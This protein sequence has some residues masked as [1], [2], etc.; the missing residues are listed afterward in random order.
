MELA[1]VND[2]NQLR[3]IAPSEV[4]TP[5][6]RTTSDIHFLA[7][8]TIPIAVEELQKKHTIPVFAKDNESTIS[9]QEFIETVSYVTNQIF[10]GEQILKPAIRVS[11]PI[12][13]RIPSAVGKPA[14]EL[15]EHEKTLYFERMA[16]AIEIASITD[17]VAGNSLN[18]TVGGVRAYN[19]E[20]MHSTKREEHFRLFIGFK[21][22]VCCNLCISTDGFKN[23][24]KVRTIAE[25]AKSAYNLFGEFNV[26]REI[27]K[28][29]SLP[30]TV[31][32][33]SQF[34]QIVGRARLYQ[35]M[36]WKQRKDLP[37]FPLSDSQ[38]NLVVKDYYSDES[39]C[40]N[41]HGDINLWKLFNLFTGANKMSYIDSFLDR[42]VGCQQFVYGLH[43]AIGLNK[44]H[45]FVN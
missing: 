38:V 43:E 21:N 14:K 22:S 30:D 26:Y 8:N 42:N 7:A 29:S 44:H 11:H 32:T 13:G 36:P 35:N 18:L 1:K 23:D 4:V 25:L 45:W 24:I 33:E 28:Y 2:K 17:K 6:Q 5:E 12:K 39:F 40:K 16:F 27:D 9:H 3:I 19:L 15:L 20:N 41:E 10:N 31:I 34:A 37:Q